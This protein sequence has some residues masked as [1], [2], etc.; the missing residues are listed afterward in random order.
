MCTGKKY[1]LSTYMT[2]FDRSKTIEDI[3][4]D[5]DNNNKITVVSTSLIEAGVDLDF[6]AVFREIAGLDSLLQSAGRCNREGKRENGYMYIFENEE[7]SK[8][9]SDLAIRIN[10]ARG[11]I[12]KNVTA[13][14]IDL[15]TKEC[16][17]IYY[18]KLYGF[19]NDK[20]EKNSIAKQCKDPRYLPFRTYAENFKM[21]DSDTIAIVIDR[22]ENSHEL[23]QDLR[24]GKK[25]VMRKLQKYTSNIYIWEFEE[26]YRQGVLDDY[27]TGIYCLTNKDYYDDEIGLIFENERIYSV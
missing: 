23:I 22:D 9:Q 13:E 26:L 21:I 5:L 3:R 17:E 14:D 19:N 27:K 1:H 8:K 16:I 18:E 15:N 12:N 2:N 4:I 7:I 24:Y 6:E 25:S 20:I 11:I 10:I